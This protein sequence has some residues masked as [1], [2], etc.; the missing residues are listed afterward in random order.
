ML[1]FYA[2]DHPTTWL[3]LQCPTPS[4]RTTM[5]RSHRTR[6]NRLPW[7][8]LCRHRRSRNREPKRPS[9][10]RGM[11]HLSENPSG[12]WS[13]TSGSFGVTHAVAGPPLMVSR[14]LL[15]VLVIRR[16]QLSKPA[17]WQSLS[18]TMEATR[19]STAFS[20]QTGLNRTEF[21]C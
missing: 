3:T 6:R 10:R 7:Q 9:R 15:T 4:K 12:R 21:P 5:D 20:K 11:D 13:I 17:N 1:R 8:H 16:K 18:R 14:K 2:I 19:S